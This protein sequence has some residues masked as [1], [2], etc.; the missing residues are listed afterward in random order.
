MIITALTGGQQIRGSGNNPR[1]MASDGLWLLNPSPLL[2]ELAEK[3]HLEREALASLI[4]SK[5][6]CTSYSVLLTR[7]VLCLGL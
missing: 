4:K 1:S 2:P 7:D 5:T 3:Q 6:Q